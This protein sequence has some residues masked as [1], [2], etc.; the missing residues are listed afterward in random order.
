[1][2]KSNQKGKKK[3]KKKKKS[4]DHENDSNADTDNELTLSGLLNFTDGL[5]SC[6]GSER[7]FVFTTNHIEK[8]DP[9][10]LRSGRMD[11]HIHL[12]YCAFQGF[13]VLAKNYLGVEEHEMF[14]EIRAAMGEEG[15]AMTPAEISEVLTREKRDVDGALRSLVK[16]LKES[17][18]KRALEKL[19]LLKEMEE[20]KE[21][22]GEEPT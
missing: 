12:S 1:M 20:D 21:E 5:W 4:K 13:L 14:D 17:K 3:K 8:L 2:G 16:E 6:C 18:A 7:L 22:E 9:A 19:E 10:L 15:V 11:M